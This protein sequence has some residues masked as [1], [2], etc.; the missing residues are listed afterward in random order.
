MGHMDLMLLTISL[1]QF[2]HKIMCAHHSEHVCVCRLV[3]RDEGEQALSKAP[4]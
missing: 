4:K 2:P 3:K 1:Q